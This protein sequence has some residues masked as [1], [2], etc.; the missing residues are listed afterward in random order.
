MK[1]T[2][3]QYEML[4]EEIMQNLSTTHNLL[5][6]T[7]VAVGVILS[8][9]MINLDS[10]ALYFEPPILFIP[11]FVILIVI[12]YRLRIL[13]TDNISMSTYMEVFLEPYLN[14]IKWETH[15][16]KI[17]L[18]RSIFPRACK[19]N[20]I[21]IIALYTLFIYMLVA[22][23]SLISLL[24]AGSLNTIAFTICFILLANSSSNRKLRRDYIDAWRT[25]KDS[26]K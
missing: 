8:Y 11:I 2:D 12:F 17:N 7:Y 21:F 18:R 6:I 26:E 5:T 19:P 25:I 9:I 15:V 13:S 23:F 24:F 4:R 1:Y 20:L 14:D 10:L 22:N 16:H 3:K